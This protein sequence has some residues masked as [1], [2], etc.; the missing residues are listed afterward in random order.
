MISY[1]G[2]MFGTVDHQ[3]YTKFIE[4]KYHRIDYSQ[5]SGNL[6]YYTDEI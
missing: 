3:V 2:D 5:V 6:A 4:G 1:E